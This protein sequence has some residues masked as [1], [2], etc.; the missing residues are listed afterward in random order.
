MHVQ[1]C[2]TDTYTDVEMKKKYHLDWFLNLMNC[3]NQKRSTWVLGCTMK[4]AHAN[5]VSASYTCTIYTSYTY[6]Q[7]STLFTCT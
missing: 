5:I 7:C 3:F 6:W 1:K 2:I 4:Y